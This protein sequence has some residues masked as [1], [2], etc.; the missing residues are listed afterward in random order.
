MAKSVERNTPESIL[1]WNAKSEWGLLSEEQRREFLTWATA[2]P[3]KRDFDTLLDCCGL[4]GER[5]VLA[6]NRYCDKLQAIREGLPR[7]GR[8]AM[9]KIVNGKSYN[10]SNA[11]EVCDIGN[12]LRKGDFKWDDSALY[13]TKKGAYFLAG[14]GGPAS[15]WAREYSNMRIGGRGIKPLSIGEALSLAE[16]HAPAD[17]IEEFF[18]DMIEEA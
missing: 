13:V 2:G 9:K 3:D 14:E 7:E 18:G 8:R 16:E 1:L 12:G 15:R 10:T 4:R 6:L 11:T 17:V 5:L